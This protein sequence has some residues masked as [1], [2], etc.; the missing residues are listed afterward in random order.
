MEYLIKVMNVLKVPIKIFLP[1]ASLCCGALLFFSD[2]LLEKLYLLKWK[3][4]NGFIIG[5]IF[6]V[7]ICLIVVYGVTYS[8]QII[9]KKWFDVTLK[10]RTYKQLIKMSDVEKRIIGK[11]YSSEG[12]TAVLDFNQPIVKAMLARNFI[13]SGGEQ[14]VIYDVFDN[15]V[16]ITATLQPFVCWTLDL[17]LPKMYKEMLKKSNEMQCLKEGEKKYRIE[18]ALEKLKHSYDAL[19]GNE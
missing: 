15:S 17:Y 18:K 6:L 4:E 8:V 10:L 3:H 5:I 7:T 16:P 11:L 14:L 2:D 1:T 9:R 12:Y 13:Y 19:K